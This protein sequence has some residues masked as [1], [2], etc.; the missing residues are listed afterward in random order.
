M[1]IESLEI[2]YSLQQLHQLTYLPHHLLVFLSHLLILCFYLLDLSFRF[3]VFNN[4]SFEI[5]VSKYLPKI[6]ISLL[7]YLLVESPFIE[8]AQHESEDSNQD[9]QTCD[10]RESILHSFALVI[11]HSHVVIDR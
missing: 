8:W 2:L 11:H 7:L 6:F 3:L 4:C 1:P 9:E 10:L 5:L